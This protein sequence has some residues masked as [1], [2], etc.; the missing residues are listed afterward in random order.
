VRSSYHAGRHAQG[1]EASTDD[2]SN[3]PV[4]FGEWETG[5]HIAPLVQLKGRTEAAD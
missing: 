1:A 4:F 5:A 2:Y 3:D